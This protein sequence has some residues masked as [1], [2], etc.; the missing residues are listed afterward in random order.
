MKK[1]PW[2][3]KMYNE[4]R[5]YRH[6]NGFEFITCDIEDPK[7]ICEESLIFALC[8]FITE[9]KKVNGE[10]F[11]GKTLY[12]II[13]CIQFHLECLGFSYKL[14]NHAA[15]KDLKFTLDN[16]MKMRTACGIGIS[17]KQAE[18]LSATDEDYL[19]SLGTSNPD[20]LL[21]T[22]V[23]CIRKGFALHAGQEHRALHNLSFSS[24]FK[25]IKNN[26]GEYYMQYTED[27]GLKTNKGGLKHR[28][29]LPKC[30]ALYATDN[31]ERC[32]LRVILK[33]LSLLPKTKTCSTFYLQPRKKF[34]GKSW[35]IN[36]PAGVNR[37]RNVRDICQNAGLPGFYTNHSLHSTTATKMYQNAIDEQLIQEVTGH[38]SI[39]V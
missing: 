6:A 24:Q 12:D 32:P 35:Y 10:D 33:Y 3:R 37:L 11:P 19:W 14:I 20:Q 26:D 22:V 5:T 38:R 1:V 16:T 29:L 27:I 8:H 36:K 31:V 7:S 25:F 23:F 28:K 30:I 2:V 17:V 15:F 39:A 34:F 4:W 18:V 9:V 21:N 13:I